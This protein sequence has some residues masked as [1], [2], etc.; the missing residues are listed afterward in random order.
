MQSIMDNAP[1]QALDRAGVKLVVISNGSPA[2]AK[3]Y[4]GMSLFRMM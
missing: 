2:M 1:K 3:A 4:R